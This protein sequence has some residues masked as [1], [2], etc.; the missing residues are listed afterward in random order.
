MRGLGVG[1]LRLDGVNVGFD[2]S[3]GGEDVEVAVE[4]EVE[5]ETCEGERQ[6]GDISDMRRRG[7]VDEKV[8]FVVIKVEH[9]VGK[10]ANN[11]A[12]SA[13]AIIICGIDTHCA[14][15][16]TAFVISDACEHSAFDEGAVAVVLI[17][18]IGLCVVR[19][20]DVREAI[21]IVVED[22]NTERFARVVLNPCDTGDIG[23]GAVAPISEEFAGLTCVGFGGAV[24]FIDAVEG[25]EQIVFDAPFDIVGD[26][27]IQMSIFVVI[28]PCAAC[29]ETG[30]IDASGFRN[31]GKGAVTPVLEEP[32]GFKGADIDIWVAIVIVIGDSDP[33]P[34]KRC[35]EACGFGDI[36]EGAILVVAVECHGLPLLG[37]VT[38][39]IL[40]VDEQDVLPT[41]G[42]IVDEGASGSHGF[43]EVFLPEGTRVMDEVDA[44]FVCDVGELR[45]GLCQGVKSKKKIRKVI[46]CAKIATA[47]NQLSN[48]TDFS[49]PAN[50]L[51]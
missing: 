20:E 41:V 43:G 44:C 18:F 25:T 27:D 35:R 45:Q 22:A 17:E 42:V 24:G 49:T 3:V 8:A 13:G 1:N 6:E 37:W 46:K 51:V 29:A 15:C 32:I 12:L 40:S 14:G 11:E 21:G 19:L 4:V 30:V 10:V 33:H 38:F 5:E 47:L 31:V 39:P 23:E 7:I 28:E 48:F 2:V 16:D 36:G 9:F 50:F 26:V 34:V